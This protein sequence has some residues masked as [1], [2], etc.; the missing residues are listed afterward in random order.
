MSGEYHK[1]GQV[2]IDDPLARNLDREVGDPLG[3]TPEQRAWSEASE[4]VDMETPSWWTPRFRDAV[5]AMRVS[6]EL[7]RR[8][9]RRGLADHDAVALSGWRR[10]FPRTLLIPDK[11]TSRE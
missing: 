8:R 5:I 4:A 11:L 7:R 1:P 2:I 6:E 9:L 10:A 3:L